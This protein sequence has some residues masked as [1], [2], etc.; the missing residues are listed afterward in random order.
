MT[1]TATQT[2]D[3]QGHPLDSLHRALVEI[4]NRL[5]WPSEDK[6][7]SVL[8]M[9]RDSEADLKGDE[10][11]NSPAVVPP[12]PVGASPASPVEVATGGAG[13]DYGRLAAAIVAEQNRTAQ[14]QMDQA[15]A[16]VAAD[17]SFVPPG[18][19]TDPAAEGHAA[20]SS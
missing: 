16:A 19:V 14:A 5:P 2:T 4:V 15:A 1:D 8:G 20:V 12:A 18:S 9:V 17:P 11:D 6:H 10:I 7:Q 3:T 13:I